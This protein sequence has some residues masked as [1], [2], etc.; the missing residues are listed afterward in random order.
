MASNQT[1]RTRV[2]KSGSSS[3]PMS[4]PITLPLPYQHPHL[5]KVDATRKSS[6]GLTVSSTVHIPLVTCIHTVTL[7]DSSQ[8]IIRGFVEPTLLV[9]FYVL[10]NGHLLYSLHYSKQG[11]ERIRISYISPASP[12]F[13]LTMPADEHVHAA[14]SQENTLAAGTT[15]RQW[16]LERENDGKSGYRYLWVLMQQFIGIECS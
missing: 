16:V 12:A 5:T 4:K 15:P 14:P 2:I 3:L 11:Y 13:Y 8:G 9:M 1:N 10:R 7:G 6:R